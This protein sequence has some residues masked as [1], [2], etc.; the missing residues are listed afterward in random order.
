MCGRDELPSGHEDVG[1]LSTFTSF[2]LRR[3]GVRWKCLA[4]GSCVADLA[5]V[6]AD[7]LLSAVLNVL[8]MV[9]YK[10]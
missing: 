5:S 1:L 9:K 2:G 6:V 7:A 3:R 4:G 10:E 8:I